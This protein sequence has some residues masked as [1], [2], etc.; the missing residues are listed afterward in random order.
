VVS[1][2][3]YPPS[4]SNLLTATYVSP[5]YYFNIALS[6]V[7]GPVNKL[8]LAGGDISGITNITGMTLIISSLPRYGNGI[9]TLPFP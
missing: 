9:V 4:Q 2:P 8:S 7:A 5:K 3:N 1:G 6:V